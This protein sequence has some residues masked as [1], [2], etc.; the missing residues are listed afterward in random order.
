MN[1]RALTRLV[2]VTVLAFVVCSSP[3]IAAPIVPQEA[4]PVPAPDYSDA[5]IGGVALT[6]AIWGIVQIAKGNGLKG[7]ALRWLATAL[8]F[9]LGILFL[10]VTSGIPV[11]W[12][13]WVFVVFYG[14]GLGIVSWGSNDAAREIVA[15]GMRQANGGG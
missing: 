5:A 11:N 2:L 13:G 3:A 14:L 1:A 15:Q 6:F 9:G 8:G 10:L 7:L 4:P 12:Q